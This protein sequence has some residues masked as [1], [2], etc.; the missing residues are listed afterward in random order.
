MNIDKDDN[1]PALSNRLTSISEDKNRNEIEDDG[2]T[3]VEVENIKEFF[4]TDI[5]NR[6][7]TQV[8]KVFNKMFKDIK[9]NKLKK[10]LM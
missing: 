3:S 1:N 10:Y 5:K 2:L 8:L 6:P 9:N 7:A 4:D